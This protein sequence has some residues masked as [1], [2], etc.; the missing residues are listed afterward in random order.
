MLFRRQFTIMVVPD[1]QALLRRFHLR[2]GQIAGGLAGLVV[3]A[4]LALASP[5]LLF[6]NIHLSRE[7]ATL[8]AEREQLAARAQDVE[9]TVK[10]LRQKL[11]RQEKLAERFAYMVG[12]EP[13]SL[14]SAGEGS[15][16]D[17]PQ[18]AGTRYE[19]ARGEAEALADRATVLDRRL[20]TVEEA[21]GRQTERLARVPSLVPVRGLF[22]GS[23][24]W[25]KDPFTGLR[26]FHKGL[27]ISG[28]VGTPIVAP[29]DGVVIKADRDN[30]YGNTLAIGHGEGLVTRYGHLSAFKVKPGQ[31]VHRGD[32]IALMGSTGRS[33]GSHLH[34]EILLNG[35]QV[36]PLRYIG[37]DQLD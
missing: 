36:D 19:Q 1:A 29:A 14:N 3:L 22:G 24:G 9:L 31:K 6:W 20:S 35:A 30:G 27:D 17:A 12:L 37:E 28:P 32:L 23:F 16:V 25:R 5:A 13:R 10:E 8:S 7:K 33:T 18:D 21:F 2:G 34:Y 11:A 4:A 26:E 15:I